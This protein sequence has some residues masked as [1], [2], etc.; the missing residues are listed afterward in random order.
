MPTFDAQLIGRTEK[1]LNAILDRLLAGPGLT[2]HQWIALTLTVN[3]RGSIADA[4]HVDAATQRR[5]LAELA[6]AGL[7]R[8]GADGS[9]EAT[10]R[11][12]ETWREVRAAVLEVTQRLW[13]D[14]PEADLATAG[15]V[16]DTVLH[17]AT[18]LLPAA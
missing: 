5:L 2:E 12:R 6:A 8:L 3:G 18:A 17:R 11:G 1:A 10:D 14:V 16:L 7:V 15:R 13:G 9:A 4:L